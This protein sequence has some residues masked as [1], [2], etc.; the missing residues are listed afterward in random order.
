MTNEDFDFEDDGFSEEDVFGAAEFEP[1]PGEFGDNSRVDLSVKILKQVH[2]SLGLAIQMLEG[3]QTKEAA[4]QI[5]ELVTSKKAFSNQLDDKEGVKIVEGMFDGQHMIGNDGQTYNIPPNYASKSRLVEGDAL[6]LTI[7]GDGSYLFKQ[8]RPIDR[9]RKTGKLAF[10]TD[11]DGYMVIVEERPYRLLT[12]SVTYFKG[13]PGDEVVALMPKSG[14]CR[15][16]AVENILK[17]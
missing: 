13:Q 9:D 8:I 4:K 15:W 16:A 7:M 10:D 6:K 11:T 2:E 5:A 12:A 14:N 17:G 1:E 3:G